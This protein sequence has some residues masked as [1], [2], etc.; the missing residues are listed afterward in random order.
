[1]SF[2]IVIPTRNLDNLE[3]CVAAIRFAGETARII[4]VWDGEVIPD[5]KPTSIWK[6]GEGSIILGKKPFCFGMAVNQGIQ[7]AQCKETDGFI[8]MNDDALLV[9]GDDSP[10]TAMARAHGYARWKNNETYGIVS[11]AVR[12]HAG[13]AWPMDRQRLAQM[14]PDADPTLWPI[15]APH[16]RMVPFVCVYIPL[17]VFE[18]VGLLSE[19]FCGT[20][21]VPGRIEA[22]EVYGGE[23]DDMCFRVRRLGYKLGVYD[24]C[25]VDHATLHSTFRPDRKGRSVEG[26]RARFQEIHGFQMGSR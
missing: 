25:V 21:A 19:A 17:Q 5:V 7:F 18:N 13:P 16:G 12:G 24:G 8:I 1:M 11:A 22:Q 2:T 9:A 3:Q 4:V 20:V 10:L 14:Y 15:R 23:D 26:A 6:Q